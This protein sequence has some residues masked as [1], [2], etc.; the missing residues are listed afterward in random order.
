MT[1]VRHE[2]N[3]LSSNSAMDSGR[4]NF[5]RQVEANTAE[6]SGDTS[7]IIW[8]MPLGGGVELPV[9][10]FRNSAIPENKHQKHSSS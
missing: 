7:T 2:Q 4:T 9:V 1:E 3:A 8:Y 5:R 10:N 6:A